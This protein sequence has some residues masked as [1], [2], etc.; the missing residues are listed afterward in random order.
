M[1]QTVCCG[2]KKYMNS[3]KKRHLNENQLTQL[4]K[5]TLMINN[6]L[7]LMICCLLLVNLHLFE[8]F[9]SKQLWQI[10]YCGATRAFKCKLWY[11]MV[12]KS[13]S[14]YSNISLHESHDL[15]YN[16]VKWVTKWRLLLQHVHS[17]KFAFQCSLYY[18]HHQT[19]TNR[20]KTDKRKEE[21]TK[22]REIDWQ[23]ACRW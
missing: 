1:T 22:E 4:E 19:H 12:L 13:H 7:K 3:E 23:E 15:M 20:E 16:S 18:F 21:K 2:V 11:F 14:A 10:R 17:I 8:A 5:Q 6:P 9:C